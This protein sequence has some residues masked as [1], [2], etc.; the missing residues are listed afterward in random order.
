MLIERRGLWSQDQ[1]GDF[2]IK[3][4]KRTT[5]VSD[6]DDRSR[7]IIELIS[8]NPDY[9]PFV[10]SGLSENEISTPAEFVSILKTL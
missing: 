7:V 6:S 2:V 9:A 1:G 10:L 5:A 3:K 8:E 4:Y